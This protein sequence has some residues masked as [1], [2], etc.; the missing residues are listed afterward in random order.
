MKNN[1]II[2]IF[3]LLIHGCGNGNG[4]T[5]EESGTIEATTSI[6]SSEVNG[7]IAVV[8]NDEGSIV[9]AGDTVILIDEELYQIKYEQALAAK[10]AA[11]AQYELALNGARNE[12]IV[13]AEEAL[14]QADANFQSAK[15]D[16]ERF[17]RLYEEKAI[18]KKQYDDAVTKYDITFSQLNSAKENL[19]KIKSF[20]RPEEIKQAKAN[21][22][23]AEANLKLIEKNINDCFIISPIKGNIVETFVEK[24][25][26]VSPMSSLFKVADLSEV[27]LSIYI[28]ETDLGKI[29]LR[30]YAEISTDSFENKTYEGKVIYISPEAEFTPKNIQTKDERT[31]LVFEVKIKIPNPNQELKPGMPADAV[32]RL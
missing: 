21:L 31:K 8:K 6:I 9:N 7:K 4:N 32:I 12:D 15:N 16:K 26:F 14:K 17:S 23:Q 27:E 25:E 24:G 11:E 28:S 10:N 22:E 13:Q 29:K 19:S 1:L 18:T 20:S 30:D 5:I 3:L 2:I